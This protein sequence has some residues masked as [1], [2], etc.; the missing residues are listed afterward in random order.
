MAIT[1]KQ[2]ITVAAILAIV[3]FLNYIGIADYISLE[4][5]KAHR[6][7]L[8]NL[9]QT[10]YYMAVL[11]YILTYIGIVISTAPL[12]AAF[13]VTGGFLF[14]VL[15]GLLYATVA[16]VIGSLISFL[17]FRH[18]LGRWLQ[19]RYADRLA[20]FNANMAR[21]GV[22][23]ILILHFAA[24]IPFSVINILVAL[25]NVPVITFV[26]TTAVGVFPSLLIFSFMG[27]QL[28]QV[29]SALEL[30]TPGIIG[31]LSVLILLALVPLI[32]NKIKEHKI[33]F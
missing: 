31:G 16:A 17:L 9:V 22:S 6:A 7:Y 33:D 12:A 14:G 20:K 27:Q 19:T 10:H 5:L 32:W 8:Q 18:F 26:W 3:G 4:S 30:L 15:P 28:G 23:F 21:Y 13:T 11:S 29:N 1:K 24:I 2:V 25:T